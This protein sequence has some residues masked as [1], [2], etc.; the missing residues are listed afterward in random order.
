MTEH[1]RNDPQEDALRH[2]L[3]RAVDDV[4]PAPDALATIRT[5]IERGEGR[6]SAPARFRSAAGDARW[7]LLARTRPDRRS[8]H[9]AA[10][11]QGLAAGDYVTPGPSGVATGIRSRGRKAAM[12]VAG[13]FALL[14]TGLAVNQ[15][16]ADDGAASPEAA[17]R[18][19]FEAIDQ[20]DPLGVL[21]SLSPNEREVLVPSVRRLAE[22]LK[23]FDVADDGLDLEHVDGLDLQVIDLELRTQGL[24]PDVARVQVSG[25]TIETS[26]NFRELPLGLALTAALEEE[27]GQNLDEP[28]TD[29][30]PL[31]L[32][33]A[34]TKTG[35]RWHV[36]LL[37]SV[38]EN[39][40]ARKGA[41]VPDFGNGIPA[42]GTD[43]PQAAVDAMVEAFNEQDFTRMIELT[44]LDTAAVLHDY[45]PVLLD[46]DQGGSSSIVFEDISFGEPQ[47]SGGT[48]TLTVERYRMVESYGGRSYATTVYDGGCV[49]T[50]FSPDADDD[51]REQP[52]GPHE[53]CADESTMG[54]GFG[55]GFA[56]SSLLLF[57]PGRTEIL[58]V[59]RDGAWYVDPAWSAVETLL[60]D[61]EGASA[62]QINQTV[63]QWAAMANG[64]DDAWYATYGPSYYDNCPGVQAPDPGASFE[65][66]KDAGR[67]CDEEQ[68]G[69]G[70]GTTA[71]SVPDPELQCL[72]AGDATAVETCLQGLGDPEALARFH[73]SSC[74]SSDDTASVEA[75]LQGL[76]D[77]GEIEPAVVTE[78][79]CEVASKP[80]AGTDVDAAEEAYLQCLED[81]G[82]GDTG[83]PE[84]VPLGP[85]RP[86]APP[87]TTG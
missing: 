40:R 7:R 18:D 45:G 9:A 21:E 44:P 55:I 12:A 69:A 23:R 34:T 31:D 16:T 68:F 82:V 17:V 67:R 14:T 10:S 1:P 58:V 65:E 37:Y 4:T 41:P 25:G 3:S 78:Y 46:D 64:D 24:H 47:G 61:I 50:T 22:Q 53:T 26:A 59:E 56:P 62:E 73:E 51:D 81:A 85:P 75:C 76:V 84:E 8:A 63:E 66:R 35:D 11:G 27:G 77:T 20:E 42:R 48:R 13:V 86:I 83:E 15:L 74:R 2:A 72:E 6:L 5:R 43:S 29:S 19:F 80:L 36:S 39:M 49:T 70:E 79:R 87:T 57:G 54:V 30:I 60:L 32:T 52:S 38:A 33:L 28:L 71:T